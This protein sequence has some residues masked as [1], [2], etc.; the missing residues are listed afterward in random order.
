MNSL[1]VRGFV[2]ALFGAMT[3]LFG[4]AL[5]LD[6]DQVALLGV[7][8]GAVIGLVPDQP[9]INRIGGFAI[10]FALAWVGYAVRAAVLPDVPMGRA[11]AVFGVV[12]VAGVLVGL[13]A[14]RLP[15]WSALIGAAAM[16]GA[17]EQTYAASPSLFTTDS[18][19]AATTVLLASAMGV[20]GSTLF[21]PGRDG[22]VSEAGARRTEE[23]AA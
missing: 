3:V 12:A 11:V 7:A 4:R 1:F 9:I 22:I 10:G 8:L 6:L 17:Y 23:V 18:P 20:L 16:V 13:T 14:G 5:A 2:L 15:L 19:T 21:G